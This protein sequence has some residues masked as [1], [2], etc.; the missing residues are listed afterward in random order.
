[1]CRLYLHSKLKTIALIRCS[2]WYYQTNIRNLDFGANS[3]KLRVSVTM[4]D[5]LKISKFSDS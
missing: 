5:S 2:E 1:M 3:Y 4:S